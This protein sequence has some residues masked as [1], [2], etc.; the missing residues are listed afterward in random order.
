MTTDNRK[1]VGLLSK[2]GSLMDLFVIIVIAL[3]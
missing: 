1:C 3:L 2:N